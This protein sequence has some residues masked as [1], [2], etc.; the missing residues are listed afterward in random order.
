MKTSEV[1]AQKVEE[2]K[3]GNAEAFSQV[4]ED[5]YKYLHTCVI[6][7]VKNEDAAQD[8]LQETYV[9]IFKNIGQLKSSEDFLSWAAPIA[10]RKCFA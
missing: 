3:K 8:M 1:L 5:S 9:E 10:N 2:L 6:H 4:Y 7:I